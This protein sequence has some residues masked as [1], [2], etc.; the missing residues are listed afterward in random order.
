MMTRNTPVSLSEVIK[1]SNLVVEVQCVETFKEE[2]AIKTRESNKIAPP[3]M[4]KGFVF[5][6]KSIFKNTTGLKSL[7]ESIQVPE[8]NWR[9]AMSEHTE[10]YADGPGR[11]YNIL[12]Y[13]TPLSSMKKAS[14]LFL[15]HFQGMFDLSAKG[16]FESIDAREKIEMII[17]SQPERKG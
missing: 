1:E 4:K 14:F 17:E 2:V 13:E 3:F 12:E 16:A 15:Q 9:R 11:S 10:R 7:P 5:I 8:E 6:I